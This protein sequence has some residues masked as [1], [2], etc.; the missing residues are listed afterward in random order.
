MDYEIQRKS[1]YYKENN[2]KYLFVPVQNIKSDNE[3]TTDIYT[4]YE[5]LPN[6]ENIDGKILTNTDGYNPSGWWKYITVKKKDL[7]YE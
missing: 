5:N 2:K 3:I 4:V 1:I 6:T 7:I